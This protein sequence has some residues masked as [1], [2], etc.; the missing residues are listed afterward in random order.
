MEEEM[1]EEMKG[2]K[3]M[4]DIKTITIDKASQVHS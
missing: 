4:L 3:V 1:W 2:I